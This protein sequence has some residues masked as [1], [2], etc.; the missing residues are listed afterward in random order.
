MHR[1]IEYYL[2]KLNIISM[3]KIPFPKYIPFQ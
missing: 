3:T 1:I 2:Q